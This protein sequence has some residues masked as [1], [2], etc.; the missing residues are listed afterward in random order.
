MTTEDDDFWRKYE[1]HQKQTMEDLVK[2]S[3][4]EAEVREIIGYLIQNRELMR[5]TQI[6]KLE[7]ESQNLIRKLK[8]IEVKKLLEEI[9]CFKE[10]LV[11]QKKLVD[12]SG[13]P[14]QE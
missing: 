5:D 11:L 3:Q 10:V 14:G 1:A 13:V 7:G 2:Y 8:G 9:E 12:S 6:E 4:S